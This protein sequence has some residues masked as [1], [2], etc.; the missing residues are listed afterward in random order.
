MQDVEIIGLLK[1]YVQ[2]TLVG[3]GALKGANCSIQ[4]ITTSGLNHVVTFA[5]KDDDGVSH[6]DTMTVTD[7]RSGTDGTDGTDGVGITSIEKTSTVGLVDTYTITLT[8]GVTQDFTVT[9]GKDG[10]G[11]SIAEMTDV[12]ITG[13]S[14][15]QILRYNATTHKWENASLANVART[16]DYNDL[17]NPPTLGTAAEKNSTNQVVADSTDLVE[18]G[19]VHEAIVNAVST[20]YKPSGDKTVAEL[21]SS[22]LVAA[23]L[24]N[25][26][27]ITDS[28]VTTADFVGGAGQT[29]NSGD[30]VA[31][32]D[33]GS[34]VYMFDLLSGFVDLSG[35]YTKT[36]TDNA[37]DT[38]I[39]K[40]D[41]SDSAVAGS[42]VTQVTETD[43][44]I[45]VT[46]E[47]ADAA[48]AENSNK[49]VKSGGVYAGL[50]GKADKVSGATNGNFAGLDANGNLTDSGKKAADF[51]T[52]QG[53]ANEAETRAKLGAHNLLNIFNSE[54]NVSGTYTEV[55]NSDGTVTIGGT[56]TSACTIPYKATALYNGSVYNFEPSTNYVLDSGLSDISPL[57]I[58]VFTKADA[59]ASWTKIAE[60]TSNTSLS[61]TTPSSFYDIW[62]RILIPANAVVPANTVVKPHIR[63]ATDL[64]TEY[65][66][67]VPTNAECLSMDGNSVLG[68]T[69]IMKYPY[70]AS[71]GTPGGIAITDNGDGTITLAEGT[72]SSSQSCTFWFERYATGMDAKPYRGKGIKFI[73]DVS[74]AL[75]YAQTIARIEFS[76]A[77]SSDTAIS[78]T[79]KHVPMNQ[80]RN[81]FT[82]TVPDNADHFTIMMWIAKNTVLPT[83]T[84]KPMITMAEYNGD[85]V[86]YAPTNR[87][88]TELLPNGVGRVSLYDWGNSPLWMD[89][90]F[91]D[92]TLTEIISAMP[93]VE[94]VSRLLLGTGVNT[95]SVLARDLLAKGLHDSGAGIGYLEIT[96]IT[97]Y[98]N[99]T[100]V[101]Y[102]FIDG[103]V[104]KKRLVS[105]RDGTW[106]TAQTI[107]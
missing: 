71:S 97:S 25:V 79:A 87:D 5:W 66:P 15:G 29:I 28:G 49:L 102:T 18:S 86:P 2:A 31:I 54:I 11:G 55:V 27:N 1:T 83:F 99:R 21:I 53:L 22:L 84:L 52:E 67:Y 36:E 13:V 94:R 73:L 32:I 96:K 45:S 33:A 62:A 42:Y 19:A 46:R 38:E 89:G 82:L 3:M 59:S 9:N 80:L 20:V 95:T 4:S 65:T 37:I 64:Y 106:T 107:L 47:A 68:A 72:V 12:T 63:L 7:G 98:Q 81:E 61:F 43:G 90:V 24:G 75:S 17:I 34:G 77:D 88:M 56:P 35:Y 69:N 103:S 6:T 26:Y 8:N 41:V 74:E 48:P 40:L 58:Q 10:T 101:E 91:Q 76:V 39:K 51:A 78:G 85:Y 50:A 23:N 60:T 104:V 44:K 16:G 93:D 14:D 105:L 100:I 30:S 92:K 57:Y 70:L